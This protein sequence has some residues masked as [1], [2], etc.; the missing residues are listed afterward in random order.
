[1]LK[2]LMLVRKNADIS[3][4]CWEAGAGANIVKIIG[5]SRSAPK[6]HKTQIFWKFRYIRDFL[7][8]IG[9]SKFRFWQH[10]GVIWPPWP[11]WPPRCAPL[12]GRRPFTASTSFNFPK[13]WTASRLRLPI[14][15]RGTFGAA[16]P[17]SQHTHTHTHIYIYIRRPGLCE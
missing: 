3:S 11:S 14:P 12:G 6:T 9:G 7:K 10:W 4:P 2:Y 13:K 1:M 15:G 16:P 5:G 8:I 17:T